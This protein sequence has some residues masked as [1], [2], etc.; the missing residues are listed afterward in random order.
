MATL[1]ISV[2]N[3]M[4][5]WIDAQVKSG[6]YVNASDYL[7]DLI[8][9]NQAAADLVRLALIEGEQSGESELTIKEII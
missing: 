3:E 2:P 5:E 9:N 6:R 8:R 4:R 1:N 7:R